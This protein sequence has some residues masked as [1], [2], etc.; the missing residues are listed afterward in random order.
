MRL[1]LQE[2]VYRLGSQDDVALLASPEANGLT[3]SG[4]KTAD[5][6]IV[7]HWMFENGGDCSTPTPSESASPTDSATP[8]P[9]ESAS[10]SRQRHAHADRYGDPTPT[11]S[12]EAS[13][14]TP[15][16]DRF[17]RSREW[18]PRR[19]AARHLDRWLERW[20]G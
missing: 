8:T 7:Q 19:D 16:A 10:P 11:G 4:G 3:Q 2:D 12:A 14:G 17:G 9:S 5:N 15:T 1:A 13:S 18:H 6:S 20:I